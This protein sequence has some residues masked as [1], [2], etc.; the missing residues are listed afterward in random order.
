MDNFI[1]Q[2]NLNGLYGHL[3]ELKQLIST[4]KPHILC[5]QESLLK[6]N[7]SFN[8]PGYNIY[9]TDG[10][11]DRRARGGVITC[12]KNNISSQ[13]IM[14]N[15]C[16]KEIVC[17]K[18]T[19]PIDMYICNIYL[20]PN[21]P[22]QLNELDNIIAQIIVGDLNS[23]NIIWNSR[24]SDHRGRIIEQLVTNNNLI[25]LN[26][27]KPTHFSCRE[28][29]F[30]IIDL[31]IVS[32]QIA[33]L[34]TFDT[35][36]DLCSSDHY[37][38]F[39]KLLTNRIIESRRAKWIINRANWKEFNGNTNFLQSFLNQDIDVLN[40]HIVNTIVTSAERFIPRSSTETLRLP[41]PWWSKE[42]EVLI[43]KRK[44]A[45]FSSSNR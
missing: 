45:F 26:N 29:S 31:A 17:I 30:S 1:L 42:I 18:T 43:H 8:L 21:Q 11:F 5:L 35:S 25:I 6:P 16:T 28:G 22:F 23:H 10:I 36:D 20:P 3:E 2:W 41:V 39:I 7:V 44:K 27:N 12:V 40:S 4:H 37:P 32:P 38:I 14:L 13:E 33:T 19:Y 24:L 15:N 34:F 9:R